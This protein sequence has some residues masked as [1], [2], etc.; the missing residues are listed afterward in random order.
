MPFIGKQ[1]AVGAYSKLDAITTSATATYNLTLD[2]GA[3]YPSSANHLLVSLN[4]VMQAPQDSFTINGATIVFASTLA[5]TDT[6]DFIMA[7]GD[8]LDIGTPSDGTV[9]TAKMQ[10]SAVTTAKIADANIT[11]AKIAST[12]DLSGKTVTYGL[13]DSDM[14]AGSIIQVVA[15]NPSN[16][17]SSVGYDSTS[18]TPMAQITVTAKSAN[19]K[20]LINWSAEWGRSVTGRSQFLLADSYTA[21]VSNIGTANYLFYSHYGNYHAGGGFRMLTSYSYYDESQTIA[22]GSSITY[23]IFGGPIDVATDTASH[24]RLQVMEVSV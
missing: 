9:T 1:P 6:I 7:L 20:F 5:S 23:Y 8:V 16:Y 19:S 14:P 18:L 4:G 17:S 22:Q 10:D 21:G 2:S 11:T 12:L 15:S 24:Q 3:Y 13:T